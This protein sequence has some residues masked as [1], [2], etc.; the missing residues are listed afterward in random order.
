MSEQIKQI[1]NELKSVPEEE[2]NNRIELIEDKEVKKM[3]M[4]IRARLTKEFIKERGLTDDDVTQLLKLK[5]RFWYLRRYQLKLKNNPDFQKL[6]RE[7]FNNY[8]SQKKNDQEFKNKN[9]MRRM[10]YLEKHNKPLPNF[11]NR[12]FNFCE[13]DDVNLICNLN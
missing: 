4:L 3:M 6:N 7:R 10:E 8:Y 2:L 5:N 13:Y 11:R 12:I 9:Y 1:F